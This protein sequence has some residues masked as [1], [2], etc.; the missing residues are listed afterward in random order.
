MR[1]LLVSLYFCDPAE[2]LIRLGKNGALAF[3]Y[4]VLG[5]S[6]LTHNKT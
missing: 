6:T 5:L 3:H 1:Y 2:T 4:L